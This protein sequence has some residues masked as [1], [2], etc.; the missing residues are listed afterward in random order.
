MTIENL[1]NFWEI[2]SQATFE[3]LALKTFYFQYENNKV[4]R[5]FCDLI[6]C[7]PSEVST[8]KDIP[9]LP[10]SFFKSKRVCS[11]EADHVG[12]FSSSTTNSG[13]PSKHYYRQ[14]QDYQMSFR[15][16]FEYFFGSIED[17]RVLALLPSYM[18]R[19]GSSLI[20]MAN[21]MIRNSKQPESGFYLNQWESL[22]KSIDQGEEKGQKTLLLGVSFALLD[23][24]EK[25]SF[26]LQHTWIMETG[27]MKG[28]RK[29][30]TREALHNQ[31]KKGFGVPQIYSEYGMTELLSQA[32]S[33]GEGLFDCPP[34][35]RVAARENQDPF[36]LLPWGQGGGLNIIDLANRDSCAF[37][38]TEDLGKVHS[39]SRFE[40]LG[41]LDASEIRGCNLM[42][43]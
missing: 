7:H 22:K 16:G 34:W 39:N 4:Y 30:L 12:F 26:D 13:S 10:I 33:K 29:E 23:F 28:R 19:S 36:N 25:Y 5:S 37:I 15:K 43:V 32:Y 9:Y 17:F 6:N 8:V 41:R 14:L 21:D 11:F 27:G 24:L 18:E 40:V 3:A 42:V 35:M 2:D 20:Y 1:E 38:A 31:L